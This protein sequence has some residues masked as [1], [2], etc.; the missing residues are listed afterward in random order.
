[1]LLR[2]DRRFKKRY[3]VSWEALLEIRFS[4]FQGKMPITVVNFSVVGALLH[5]KQIFLNER[6]L[7]ATEHPPALNLK[8]FLSECVFESQVEIRWYDWSVEMNLFE[9]GVKFINL[10]KEKKEDIRKISR[11]LHNRY[12]S[13][14]PIFKKLF[15]KI[16]PN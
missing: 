1:M 9:I 12:I 11:Q 3:E 8:I 15:L 6:H 5:S 13:E 2:E 4:D 16:I 7:I 10:S 14:V